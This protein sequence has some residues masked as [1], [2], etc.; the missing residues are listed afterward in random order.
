MHRFSKALR[1]V[2]NR[3]E[4]AASE[5]SCTIRDALRVTHFD[6]KVLS[7]ADEHDLVLYIDTAA[8]HT[9]GRKQNAAFHGRALFS[10]AASPLKELERMLSIACE[11]HSLSFNDFLLTEDLHTETF[12]LS[13]RK[14]YLTTMSLLSCNSAQKNCS[15]LFKPRS[16]FHTLIVQLKGTL[17]TMKCV[18]LA[19][20]S[21][22][23]PAFF[24]KESPPGRESVAPSSPIGLI[25]S[26]SFDL[27]IQGKTPRP[28]P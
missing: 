2:E 19:R 7:S 13:V 14:E 22:K 6:R 12:S 21:E 9:G 17:F 18:S 10:Y 28:P 3:N 15:L 27:F 5:D 4:Y 16:V 25:S 20:A 8:A 26:A 11:R 24:S 23:V 1:L